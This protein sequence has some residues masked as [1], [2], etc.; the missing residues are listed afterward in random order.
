MYPKDLHLAVTDAIGR[1]EAKIRAKLLKRFRKHG[2]TA[3]E[4][5]VLAAAWKRAADEDLESGLGAA[6]QFH[7]GQRIA[8]VELRVVPCGHEPNCSRIMSDASAP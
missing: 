1:S 6:E 3:R 5:D 8:A 7:V 4:V 2:L